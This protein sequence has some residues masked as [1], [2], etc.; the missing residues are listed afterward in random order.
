MWDLRAIQRL[1]A[2]SEPDEIEIDL[3]EMFGAG[4]PCLAANASNAD[5]SSYLT[6]IPGSW[7][8]AIYDRWSGRLL[9]QNVR[10]F[11]QA[12]GK[13]NKGIRKTILEEPDMF[14]AYNNGISRDC[15]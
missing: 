7:L 3:L 9:E 2:S 15:Q 8:A 13:V 10:T 14:F 5:S 6:V 11:L 12:K 1:L 4:L